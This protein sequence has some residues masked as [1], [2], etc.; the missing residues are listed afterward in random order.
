MIVFTGME[1]N[2]P[3]LYFKIIEYENSK[4]NIIFAHPDFSD[5]SS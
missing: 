5:R 2:T 1:H 3:S 4:H